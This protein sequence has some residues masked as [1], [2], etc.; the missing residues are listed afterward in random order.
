MTMS[1]MFQLLAIIVLG[2]C[3]DVEIVPPGSEKESQARAAGEA[4]RQAKLVAA[5][6]HGA[7]RRDLPL[8][9]RTLRN[10]NIAAALGS[11]LQVLH[12]DP[13]VFVVDGVLDFAQRDALAEAHMRRR[14]ESPLVE[15]GTSCVWC[16]NVEELRTMRAA[17][18]KHI[19]PST[20]KTLPGDLVPD[21]DRPRRLSPDAR[22]VNVSLMHRERWAPHYFQHPVTVNT[23]W[24]AGESAAVDAALDALEAQLG[25]PRALGELA[26]L[27]QSSVQAAGPMDSNNEARSAGTHRCEDG[28]AMSWNY[29][30]KVE[31]RS[32]CKLEV[33]VVA[34]MGPETTV[35]LPALG[36]TIPAKVS[37]LLYTVTFYANLA[38]SLTRSP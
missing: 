2:V 20:A 16:F 35:E 6:A 22:C 1:T 5:R 11:R 32:P 30:S 8:S 23:M 7:R 21:A 28:F 31:E 37:C 3:A 26:M 34:R 29:Q 10:R 18:A 9:Q 33:R 14:G 17:Y 25:L 4:E 19:S 12:R 13:D 15:N 27:A 38:H 24:R 36:I